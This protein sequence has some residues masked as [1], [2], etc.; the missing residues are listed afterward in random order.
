MMTD[1]VRNNSVEADRLFGS[2]G[3]SVLGGRELRYFCPECVSRKG[4]PDRKGHLYVHACGGTCSKCRDTG[5]LDGVFRCWR[6]KYSGRVW[7]GRASQDHEIQRLGRTRERFCQAR[8]RFLLRR[9]RR[10]EYVELSG[11]PP[12]EELSP[13]MAAYSYLMSR[14]I[15]EEHIERYRIRLGKDR[16]RGRVIIFDLDQSGSPVYWVARDYTGRSKVR[17]W[18]PSYSEVSKRRQVFNL[19]RLEVLD[20][21]ILEGSFDSIIT[22]PG[23]VALYGSDPTDEQVQRIATS[24][25]EKAYCA[26]DEDAWM[27]N[28]D[29]A[30]RL[31]RY[32]LEEVYLIKLPVGLDPADLGRE[33]MYELKASAIPFEQRLFLKFAFSS[34]GLVTHEVS[35]NRPSLA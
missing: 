13:R 35:G 21:F 22:G 23:S 25:I 12:S 5:S 8:E 2:V 1:R 3:I 11:E 6:C 18:A 4:T 28:L 7:G 10:F 19:S 24:G 20:P 33:A 29:L 14:G 9:S 27:K 31:V 15:T 34:A 26:L 16:L 32:G 17:Y 30:R